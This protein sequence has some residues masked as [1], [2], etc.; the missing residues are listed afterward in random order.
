LIAE[1]DSVYGV[2]DGDTFKRDR[3]SRWLYHKG[4]PWPRLESDWLD[5]S[6][7][8]FKIQEAAWPIIGPL[9]ELR[10]TVR[11]A[12]LDGL[13]VGYDGRARTS[14][15][16]FASVT[17][18]NQPSTRTFPFAT[19]KWMRLHRSLTGTRPRLHRFY[20]PRDRH[21]GRPVRRRTA[22]RCLR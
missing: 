1:V 16:P 10:N 15:R 21:R 9:R 20:R 14:L 22:Y 17:G 12:D 13:Q 5:L 4:I 7:D 19:A 3:F 6:D 8:A 2:Y 11:Q 18:R